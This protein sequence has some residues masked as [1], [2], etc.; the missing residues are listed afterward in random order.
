MLV[1]NQ[2]IPGK[3][4]SKAVEGTHDPTP[5]YMP[6]AGKIRDVNVDVGQDLI[7]FSL[8]FVFGSN[9]LSDLLSCYDCTCF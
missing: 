7:W 8:R 5:L 4:R 9:E 6:E 1:K 3:H 2:E